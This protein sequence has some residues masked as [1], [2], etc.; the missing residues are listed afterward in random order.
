MYNIMKSDPLLSQLNLIYLLDTS[1]SMYG[2]RINQLNVAMTEAIRVVE[3]VV[4]ENEVQIFIRVVEFNSVAK[5][6]IGDTCH[7][8][9]H[10]DWKPL[11]AGGAT[12][13]A[14]AI[15][16]A[17]S[18]MS[19][20]YLGPSY[21]C[22]I[23]ILITDGESN[24]PQE[25]AEAVARLKVCLNNSMNPK[26]DKIIRIA[27]GVTD[28]NLTELNNF[29]SVGHIKLEDGT[30]N[31]NVPLVFNVDDIQILKDLLKSVTISSM[32]SSI[33]KGFGGEFDDTFVIRPTYEDIWDD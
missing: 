33:G 6:L 16:L 1:S 20:N 17:R 11:R 12:D 31:E 9:E 23:V 2:E 13:T 30:M 8:V 7:G 28:A 10:V 32:V 24:D 14:G 5:W 25:T 15:D 21:Y 4:K 26:M 22:P 27:I 29:A 3:E 18:V 19:R